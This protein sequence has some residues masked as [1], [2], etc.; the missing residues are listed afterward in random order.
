MILSRSVPPAQSAKP[1]TS[2][3]V[4][5][6]DETE[7]RDSLGNLLLS[8]EFNVALF[9]SIQD[10]QKA[11]L[12]DVPTCMVLDVRLP[13][14][15]GFDLQSHLSR[16]GERIPI[17]F[18]TGYGDISMS[19][20]AMKAGAMDFLTK[21]FRDQDMLDAV[22]EGIARDRQRRSDDDELQAIRALHTGLTPREKEVMAF[23]TSGLLN[24]QIAGK[25][26]LQEITVKIHRGN[27]MRKMAARSVADLVRMAQALG[28]N[29]DSWRTKTTV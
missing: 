14:A 11:K 17:I 3:V 27:M 2:L 6:D 28:L 20:R 8:V 22:T 24:K 21:P 9:S 26:D 12:P 29:G 1:L 7:V 13:G 15:S 5:I 25:M 16:A 19:V 18:M 4:V 10:F 23:V